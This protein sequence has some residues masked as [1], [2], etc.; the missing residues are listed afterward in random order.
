MCV[1][2]CLLKKNNLTASVWRGPFHRSDSETS[3]REGGCGPY[4][5]VGVGKY[6]LWCVCFVLSDD[7]ISRTS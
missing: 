7:F 2:R 5:D 6:S 3:P 4:Q 1:Q